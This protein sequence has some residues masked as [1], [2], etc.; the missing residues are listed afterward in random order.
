MYANVGVEYWIFR[1]KKEGYPCPTWLDGQAYGPSHAGMGDVRPQEPSTQPTGVR[2]DAIMVR[3]TDPW[4]RA[5]TNSRTVATTLHR[6]MGSGIGAVP[7]PYSAGWVGEPP[8]FPRCRHG[9]FTSTTTTHDAPAWATRLSNYAM[10]HPTVS[11]RRAL[12]WCGEQDLAIEPR[13]GDRDE[14]RT[15]TPSPRALDHSGR[16]ELF[17]LIL[18]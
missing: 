4:P 1:K 3:R 11:P 13:H 15:T 8:P 17:S 16:G 6:Q 14:D 5:A 10:T 2:V 7:W 18:W 9:T 12:P